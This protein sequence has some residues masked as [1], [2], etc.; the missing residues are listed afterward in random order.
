MSELLKKAGSLALGVGALSL[1]LLNAAMT[2]GCGG[3]RLSE[4]AP[5]VAAEPPPEAASPAPAS[6]LSSLSSPPPPP[7]SAA[8]APTPEP[9]GL[10]G[11]EGDCEE[12]PYMAATK[13]P[14]MPM[15]RCKPASG[16]KSKPSTGNSLPQ[17]QQA[18]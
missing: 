13:A 10:F 9:N 14:V 11:A 8:A 1:V 16:A 5:Q 2:H 4:P 18:P 6:S 3:S 17:Q 15:R 12:A 7:A